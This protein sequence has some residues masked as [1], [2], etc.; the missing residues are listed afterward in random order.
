M[1]TVSTVSTV[2]TIGNESNKSTVKAENTDW[3]AVFFDNKLLDRIQKDAEK[4]W[5]NRISLRSS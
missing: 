5:T 1:N 2:N 3:K 4:I